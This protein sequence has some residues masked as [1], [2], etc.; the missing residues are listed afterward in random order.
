MFRPHPHRMRARANSNANPLMLLACSVDTST[1]INRFCLLCVTSRIL[2]GLG[3]ILT[4]GQRNDSLP[5]TSTRSI[6]PPLI[7]VL[8]FHQTVGDGLVPHV[9][10]GVRNSSKLQV[11][12]F[13]IAKEKKK[14]MPYNWQDKYFF[15]SKSLCLLYS[16]GS[17]KCQLAVFLAELL[18][19]RGAGQVS[20]V[21]VVIGVV[22]VV[23]GT[24]NL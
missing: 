9:I 13:Q 18:S 3:L 1:H 17:K 14:S 4:R 12:L 20:H 19:A 21:I 15:A 22:L 8:P 23:D 5:N 2:C 10:R 6:P 16:H 7:S 24:P 11:F